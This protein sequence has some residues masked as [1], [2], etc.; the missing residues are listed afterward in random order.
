MQV[1]VILSKHVHKCMGSTS[2]F[3]WHQTALEELNSQH[4]VLCGPSYKEIYTHGFR[5]CVSSCR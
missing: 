3:C 4:I 2:I 1:L 5:E